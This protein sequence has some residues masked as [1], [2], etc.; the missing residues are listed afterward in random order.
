MKHD[1]WFLK[2]I[3]LWVNEYEMIRM[4][5][6]LFSKNAST[7]ISWYWLWQ[8]FRSKDKHEKN[9]LYWWK[10]IFKCIGNIFERI[11]IWM[12]NFEEEFSPNL[13][14]SHRYSFQQVLIN[15]AKFLH[16]LLQHEP[17]SFR[18]PYWFDELIVFLRQE[19]A[20][21]PILS[22]FLRR[23][24]E[25]SRFLRFKVFPF[26]SKI[27]NFLVDIQIS[28]CESLFSIFRSDSYWSLMSN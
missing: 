8:L 3:Q 12:R 25:F 20:H 6:Y 26:L 28:I 22:D 16:E 10:L 21:T 15:V 27:F 7:K 11:I 19:S 2:P 17:I 13:L 1:G 9:L 5:N 24:L 23:E 18:H 14:F 4:I